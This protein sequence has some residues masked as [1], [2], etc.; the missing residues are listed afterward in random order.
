MSLDLAI[1]G[2]LAS[3]LG[4]LINLSL[5][6]ILNGST[7]V[8]DCTTGSDTLPGALTIFSAIG[9][10]RLAPIKLGALIMIGS[11]LTVLPGLVDAAAVS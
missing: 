6:A 2:A 8:D 5:R 11:I 1:R 4:D 3:T 7:T 9:A 10:L